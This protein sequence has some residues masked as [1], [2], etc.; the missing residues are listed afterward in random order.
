LSVFLFVLYG[1]RTE[2]NNWEVDGGDV[3]DNGSTFSLNV[4]PDVE[5]I[6][7]VQV[8]TS[9]YGAQYGKNASGTVEVETNS[10]RRTR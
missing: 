5:A 8:L 2:N 3:M 1:G 4:Y 7:E 9:N 6:D 10:N